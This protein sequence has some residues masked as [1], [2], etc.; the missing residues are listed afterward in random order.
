MS[1]ECGI[2]WYGSN[3]R[4]QVEIGKD[5]SNLFS[6]SSRNIELEIEDKTYYTRLPDSFFSKCKHLRTAYDTKERKGV[7]RLHEWI[8]INGVK[9]AKLEVVERHIKFKLTQLK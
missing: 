6:G 3:K 5:V 7:N 1:R 9:K 8:N 2:S 4:Y